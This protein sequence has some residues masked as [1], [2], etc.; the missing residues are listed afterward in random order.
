MFD[1]FFFVLK[2]KFTHLS[3]LHVYHHGIMPFECWFGA[4]WEPDHNDW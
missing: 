4:R 2:K 3:F 1:S